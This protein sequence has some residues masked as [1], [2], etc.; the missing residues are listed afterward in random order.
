M[1]SCAPA[2]TAAVAGVSAT[3]DVSQRVAK[4][5]IVAR[6][7]H[8]IRHLRVGLEGRRVKRVGKRTWIATINL[9]GLSRG[10]YVAHVSA[11]VNGRTVRRVHLY[12][13][14]YG[15]PKGGEATGP[16]SS[17]LVA[18]LTTATMGRLPRGRPLFTRRTAR[19][20]RSYGQ[21]AC[22]L[23]AVPSLPSA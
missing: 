12:R 1:P 16:N 7:G 3:N 14:L 21:P 20:D 15:N 8:T 19:P 10:T 2:A 5:R 22:S 13:V 23:A 4:L 17:P 18:A 6:A 11:R 9:R